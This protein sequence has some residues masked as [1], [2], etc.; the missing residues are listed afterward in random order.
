MHVMSKC[1]LEFLPCFT[2]AAKSP[3]KCPVQDRISRW[4]AEMNPAGRH[5][6]ENK[7]YNATLPPIWLIFAVRT[8]LDIYEIMEK[9][10][11]RGYDDL[12]AIASKTALEIRAY[13]TSAGTLYKDPWKEG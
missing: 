1:N 8:F 7:A 5:F 10:I 11:G 12:R 4:F 9:N 3:T 2:I 13:K 6:S